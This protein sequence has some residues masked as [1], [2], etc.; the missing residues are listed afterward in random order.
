MAKYALVV[1]PDDFLEDDRYGIEIYDR[2]GHAPWEP[3]EHAYEKAKVVGVLRDIPWDKI[4]DD[5]I[6]KK[7]K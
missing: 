7:D 6:M 4:K 3:A 2:Y 1:V 5:L